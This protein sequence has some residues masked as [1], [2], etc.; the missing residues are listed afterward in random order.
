MH[1]HAERCAALRVSPAAETVFT[2]EPSPAKNHF[3]REFCEAVA[4]AAIRKEQIASRATRCRFRSRG[5]LK[6]TLLFQ[7]PTPGM[8][9]HS[10]YGITIHDSRRIVP[11]LTSTGI[12]PRQELILCKLESMLTQRHNRQTCHFSSTCG[13]YEGLNPCQVHARFITWCIAATYGATCLVH[14]EL[15]Y[16]IHHVEFNHLKVALLVDLRLCFRRPP[17]V[18]PLGECF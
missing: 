5:S 12:L 4:H 1:L 13:V 2:S 18:V 6:R 10:R 11:V 15:H 7:R 8:C 3:K 14:C 16:S 17:I 9:L